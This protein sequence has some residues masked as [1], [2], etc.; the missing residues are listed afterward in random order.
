MFFGTI[1]GISSKWTCGPKESARKQKV[2]LHQ[3]KAGV[4]SFSARS[5][6]GV[7]VIGR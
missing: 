7:I 5:I 4:A 1:S 2:K 6:L 3:V